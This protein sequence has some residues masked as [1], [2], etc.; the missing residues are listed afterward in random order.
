MTSSDA[1]MPM[2]YAFL[3]VVAAVLTLTMK[4]YAAWIT[5]SVGLFAD[6]MESIVNL[7]TS[8]LLVILIRIAKAPPDHDHP[9]GHD[10]AEYFANGVQG[11]LIML[12]GVGIISAAVDRFLT[13]RALEAGGVGIALSVLAGAV[14]AATAHLLARAGK[15]ARSKALQ[16]EAQ[17]LMTDVWSSVAVLAGVGLVF[18][19]D[20]TW[21]DPLIAVAMSAFILWIGWKLVRQSVAGLMDGSLAPD[22]QAKVEAVLESYRKSQGIA[23]HALRSRIAGARIFVSVHILVPGSWTV[24]RGHE[25]LDEIEAEISE[26]LGGA[27]VLTHLEPIEEDSSFQDIDI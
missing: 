8:V 2:R 20:W 12:A 18:M 27:S 3:T 17:H 23:Y 26:V 10:K 15:V 21:L 16:G 24:F 1:S 9:H 25:L 13:P 5:A 11:T 19:T 14:N 22:C 6:A 7:V 4:F